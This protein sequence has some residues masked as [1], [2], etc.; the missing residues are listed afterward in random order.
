MVGETNSEL[1]RIN[2]DLMTK[3]EDDQF[4]TWTECIGYESMNEKAKTEDIESPT[5]APG[6]AVESRSRN[7]DKRTATKEFPAA[8]PSLNKNGRPR[9]N[10]VKMRGNGRLQIVMVPTD[11]SGVLV[12]RTPGEGDEVRMRFT[13]DDDFDR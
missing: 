11:H 7:T 4:S 10:L 9:F 6:R 8:L 5:T 12:E 1:E 13:N 2:G 3:N